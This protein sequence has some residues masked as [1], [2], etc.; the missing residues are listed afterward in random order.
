M[1]HGTRNG[2]LEVV[3]LS[4]RRIK[5]KLSVT[6]LL[7]QHM[8]HA[9]AEMARFITKTSIYQENLKHETGVLPP[10][11]FN[12]NLRGNFDDT[13]IVLRDLNK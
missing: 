9:D 1:I 3:S 11:D 2:A 4:V 10:F 12:E 8:M 6:I 5:E 13:L 7:T